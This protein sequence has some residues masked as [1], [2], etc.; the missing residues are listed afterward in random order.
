MFNISKKPEPVK[1][2]PSDLLSK[3]AIFAEIK[4]LE[5]ECREILGEPFEEARLDTLTAKSP[6][7][8]QLIQNSTFF[9]DG[10]QYKVLT[11]TVERRSPAIIL[12]QKKNKKRFVKF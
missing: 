11:G 9:Q 8:V 3:E 5:Y 4:A 6:L 2:R 10:C 1:I 7:F 12:A